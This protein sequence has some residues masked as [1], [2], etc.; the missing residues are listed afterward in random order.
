MDLDKII[1]LAKILARPYKITT[2][3]LAVLLALS[4]GI[5]VYVLTQPITIDIDAN[6][7]TSSFVN[8]HNEG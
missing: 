5:N 7:N 8:Q 6:N 4:V 3:I 1:E 2:I